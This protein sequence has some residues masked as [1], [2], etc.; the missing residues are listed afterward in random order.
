MS[1]L[2]LGRLTGQQICQFPSLARPL[3]VPSFVDQFV[4]KFQRLSLSTVPL[5]PKR[6]LTPY[7]RFITEKR[8]QFVAENANL[9]VTEIVKHL[10][11]DWKMLDE[12]AKK[13]YLEDGK[14]AMEKYKITYDAY[15]KSLS[16][17]QKEEIKKNRKV[18]R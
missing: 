17:A 1:L 18:C 15:V 4:S 12:H 2:N 6:P 9:R 10:A 3:L 5:P 13:R 16:D 7:M 8:P 14:A 11:K